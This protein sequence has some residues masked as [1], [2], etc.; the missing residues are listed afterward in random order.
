MRPGPARAHALLEKYIGIEDNPCAAERILARIIRGEGWFI[1]DEIHEHASKWRNAFSERIRRFL[2]DKFNEGTFQ[3]FALNSSNPEYIQGSCFVEPNDSPKVRDAKAKRSN[4]LK[5][6]QA[7]KSRSDEDLETV[8][9]RL[10]KLLGVDNPHPTPRSGDG[11]V[12]FYGCANFGFILKKQIL[13]AGSERNMHVWFVGQAKHYEAT[14]VS[15][16]DVRE[17][18][19]SVQLARAKLFAGNI[20]PMKNFSARLC[21]PVFS[22]FVTTGRF[23]KDCIQLMKS[24]GVVPMDGP[25]LGQFLADNN[26]GLINNQFC[27][28]CFK[29]WLLG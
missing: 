19:G 14:Q 2:N 4:T 10:L 5:L 13:P 22:I 16:R 24:V 3:V 29:E 26:V 21:D 23:S 9:V 15:T 17:I 18:V 1:G 6:Y 25:Q 11:G 7:I 20:D 8:C 28:N 12:D 27:E